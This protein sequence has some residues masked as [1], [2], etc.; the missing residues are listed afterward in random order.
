MEIH[1]DLLIFMHLLA[2][3]LGVLISLILWHSSRVPQLRSNRWLG[4]SIF[5]L[6]VAMLV[7][8]LVLSGIG[9]TVP[10][11]YR[12]GNIFALACMPFS[13]LYI[14]SVISQRAPTRWDW[15]HIL[16]IVFYVVDFMPFFLLP[17]EAKLE[18]IRSDMMNVDNALTYN[19]GWI[20]PPHTQRFIR[21]FQF[22]IYWLLE[23]RLLQSIYKL[24][25]PGLEKENK[26]WLRWAMVYVGI[27]TMLFLPSFVVWISGAEGYVYIASNVFAAFALVVSTVILF[28]RPD[29]LYGIRGVIGYA[30]TPSNTRESKPGFNGTGENG[31]SHAVYLDME[32]VHALQEKLESLMQVHAPFR[33]HGYASVDLAHDLGI[34]PYQLSAFLNNNLGTNFSDFIN[35]HRIRYCLEQLEKGAWKDLTVEGIGFECGFNNRNTFT[36]AFKKITRET[37]SA[38]LRRTGV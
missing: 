4:Y 28:L 15:L 24:H 13:Y 8:F 10:H 17:A 37:P 18:I 29:I 25:L 38:Y 36:A 35:E 33:K 31:I 20:T 21:T 32:T 7:S 19:E 34:P 11:I 1:I 30:N 27:Q 6:A 14:R 16:P 5:S 22:F 3:V 2:S 26:A 12:V 23:I 9:Y